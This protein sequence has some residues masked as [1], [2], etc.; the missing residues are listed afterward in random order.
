MTVFLLCI[1]PFLSYFQMC[2]KN[3][4]RPGNRNSDN[5]K[6]DNSAIL[7]SCAGPSDRHT[8]SSEGFCSESGSSNSVRSSSTLSPTGVTG[9]QIIR[10]SLQKS[11]FSP[12]IVEI[13]MHSCRDSAHK[14]YRVYINKWLQFC[15]EGSHDPLRP[16]VRPVLL[17][18]HSLFKKAVIRL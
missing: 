12:D 17:F 11:E 13:I 6:V 2:A 9:M 1:S 7:Y 16:V 3:N 14:Q 5:P 8:A 15:S 4:S 18:L 10:Q